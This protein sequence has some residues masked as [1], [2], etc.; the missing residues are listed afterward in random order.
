MIEFRKVF[1]ITF[2]AAVM[3]LGSFVFINYFVDFADCWEIFAESVQQSVQSDGVLALKQKI[4][5]LETV[6]E[7]YSR[8][9]QIERPSPHP[10]IEC[11]PCPVL[12]TR[13]HRSIL[14]EPRVLGELRYPAPC[15]RVI[16]SCCWG[17][18]VF[19]FR[20]LRPCFL[21]R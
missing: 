4:A 19:E 13:G 14:L 1:S 7:K 8:L 21:V 5:K 2:T 17:L 12:D 10:K 15:V 11:S 3:H 16:F 9:Q 20:A 6:S 18:C